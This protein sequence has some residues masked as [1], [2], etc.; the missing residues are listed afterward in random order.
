MQPT[1][2]CLVAGNLEI[3]VRSDPVANLGPPLYVHVIVLISL[4]YQ[5]PPA[6]R[7]QCSHAQEGFSYVSDPSLLSPR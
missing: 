5:L 1:K 4:F 6:P 3:L 2:P 7:R